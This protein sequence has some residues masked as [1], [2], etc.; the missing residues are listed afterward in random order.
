MPAK[1]LESTDRRTPLFEFVNLFKDQPLLNLN[2]NLTSC[3]L[4]HIVCWVYINCLRYMPVL[5]RQWWSAA[6]TRVGSIMEKI[7]TL[8]V[9]PVLCREEL[10]INKL[11]DV[12]NLTVVI[13]VFYS[14]K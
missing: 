1:I 2:E 6:E 14:T 5:A 11:N 8:Y 7:T 13:F 9:S 12:P 3:T 4:D 10:T